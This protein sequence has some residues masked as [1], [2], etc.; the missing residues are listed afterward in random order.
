MSGTRPSPAALPGANGR[1]PSTVT[2][3]PDLFALANQYARSLGMTADDL[4]EQV[5]I[6][7]LQQALGTRFALSSPAVKSAVLRSLQLAMD[8]Y[9]AG[10]AEAD[11]SCQAYWGARG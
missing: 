4:I 3:Q 10:M 9:D 5:L 7:E 11:K 8:A 6:R 1:P 2:L